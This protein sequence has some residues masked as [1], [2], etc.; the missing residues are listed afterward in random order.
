M[1]S[2]EMTVGGMVR[3]KNKEYAADAKP[4]FSAKAQK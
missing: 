3:R 4:L 2:L 1:S